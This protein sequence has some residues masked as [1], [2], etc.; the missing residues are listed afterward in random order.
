M[1]PPTLTWARAGDFDPDLAHDPDHFLAYDSE[2]NIGVVKLVPSPAGA[3]WLWSLFL[4]H[5]GPAFNRPTNSLCATRGQAARELR[6]CYAAFRAF[7]GIEDAERATTR[8]AM[9]SIWMPTSGFKR[10]ASPLGR[11]AFAE[12]SPQLL[13]NRSGSW[14]PPR[15]MPR[16]LKDFGGKIPKGTLI[17]WLNHHDKR[18][19]EAKRRAE[20][21]QERLQQE[22]VNAAKASARTAKWAFWAAAVTAIAAILQIVVTLMTQTSGGGYSGP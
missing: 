18:E 7:Y 6:E 9:T 13:P 15:E 19:L 22:A 1:E 4:V 14:S 16:S 20:E 12:T 5:P 21:R 2:T 10:P 17:N 11:R 8:R 3:E